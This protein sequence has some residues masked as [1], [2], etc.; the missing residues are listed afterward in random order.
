MLSAIGAWG[1]GFL[2]MMIMIRLF[3]IKGNIAG[4]AA[5]LFITVVPYG[6]GSFLFAI[7]EALK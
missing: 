2:F 5:L 7:L 4:L 6:V 1:L 3:N